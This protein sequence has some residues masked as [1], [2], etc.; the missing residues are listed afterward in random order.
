MIE[1]DRHIA[2]R[3]QRFARDLGLAR[4]SAAPASAAAS[5]S[6]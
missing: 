5:I 3:L 1:A 2:S 6:F 4:R